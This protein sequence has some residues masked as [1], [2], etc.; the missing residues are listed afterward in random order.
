VPRLSYNK[1]KDFVK[2]I[3]KYLNVKLGG[4]RAAYI[5]YGDQSR[6]VFKFN[7]PRSNVE[8]EGL[9]DGAPYVGGQRR[10]DRALDLATTLLRETRPTSPKIVI[11]LTA[12]RQSPG[13][14]RR[15]IDEAADR[16]RENGAKTYVISIGA[17]PNK[18]ELTA[19]VDRPTDIIPVRSF[20]TLRPKAPPIAREIASGTGKLTLSSLLPLM[21]RYMV[22]H[23]VLYCMAIFKRIFWIPC[24]TFLEVRFRVWVR[25]TFYV[26][27]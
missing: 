24:C 17:G 27:K 6:I 25:V 2:Q 16:L 4:S 8:F 10:M 11:L 3:A 19:L 5:S 9:V 14:N 20:N 18:N 13:V 21:A 23:F 15:L 26:C 7:G 22:H 1:E 12:G